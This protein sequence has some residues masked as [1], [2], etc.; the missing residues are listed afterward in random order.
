MTK[1]EVRAKID[2]LKQEQARLN[3]AGNGMLFTEKALAHRLG[4]QT[5]IEQEL[6]A[7]KAILD[8]A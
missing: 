5:A 8:E 4:R 6:A 7:L 1:D 3:D 2:A